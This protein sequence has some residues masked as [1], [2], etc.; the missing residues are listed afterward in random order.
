MAKVERPRPDGW[1][2]FRLPGEAFLT[3]LAG[4]E[5]YA[6]VRRELLHHGYAWL[7]VGRFKTLAEARS[8]LASAKLVHHG[9]DVRVVASIDT[10]A[11]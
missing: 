8:E 2:M 9:S 3:R 1:R 4:M 10:E 11:P 6:I 7:L 5:P